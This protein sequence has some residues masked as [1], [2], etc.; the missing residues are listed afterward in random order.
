MKKRLVFLTIF[1]LIGFGCIDFI[2]SHAQRQPPAPQLP[3]PC[4]YGEYPPC[5][6]PVPP[7]MSVVLEPIDSPI[8]APSA[9]EG[10]RIFPDK[11]TSNDGVNRKV[12]RV[13]VVVPLLAPTPDNVKVN[14]QAYDVDDL[15]TDSIIDSNGNLGD[16]NRPTGIGPG[17][18]SYSI[19][20]PGTS[21]WAQVGVDGNGEAIAYLTV[22]MQP[23]NNVVIAASTGSLE[24]VVVDGTGLKNANGISLPTADIKRTE[25]LTTWRRLHIEVDAM[26]VVQANSVTGE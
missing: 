4:G 6:P 9:G 1:G 7:V 21:S 14:L 5:P 20:D 17:T 23:G 15:S 19:T 8:T 18:L 10:K 13:K 24:G 3:E 22:T 11:N 12:V 25:L 16:D 26:G 2:V